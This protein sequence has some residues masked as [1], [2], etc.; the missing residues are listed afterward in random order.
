[1][2]SEICKKY[3]EENF[4]LYK[5]TYHISMVRR[6]VLDIAHKAVGWSLIGLTAALSIDFG[7]RATRAYSKSKEV[8]QMQVMYPMSSYL[9]IFVTKQSD[10]ASLA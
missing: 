8:T 1:V 2:K 7:I 9:H 6:E 4:H 3:H 10:R 5:T